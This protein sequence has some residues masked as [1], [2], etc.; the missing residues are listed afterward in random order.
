MEVP[1]HAALTGRGLQIVTEMVGAWGVR[2]LNEGGKVVWTK[3]NV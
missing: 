1:N 3:L 2:P